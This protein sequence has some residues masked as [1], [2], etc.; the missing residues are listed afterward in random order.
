MNR[1]SHRHRY[2]AVRNLDFAADA[3]DRVSLSLLAGKVS[4]L[5]EV[6]GQLGI[7]NERRAS[8]F[9]DFNRVADMIAVAV[10]QEYVINSWYCRERIFAELHVRICRVLQPRIDQQHFALRRR[11]GKSRVPEQ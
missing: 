3:H 1:G 4:E 2:L 10:G 7:T 11:D 8:E 9:G 5:N 6:A